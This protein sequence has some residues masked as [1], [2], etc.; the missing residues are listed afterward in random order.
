MDNFTKKLKEIQ[1]EVHAA[2]VPGY[3]QLK[4]SVSIG[5]VLSTGEKLGEAVLRADKFMYRAKQ[6]KNMVVISEYEIAG[7]NS[8]KENLLQV[9]QG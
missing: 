6:R 5:G 2:R 7:R 4:V 9:K 8:S 3:S 1:E